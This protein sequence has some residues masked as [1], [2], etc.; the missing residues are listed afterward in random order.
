[1]TVRPSVPSIRDDARGLVDPSVAA[2]YLSVDRVAPC[3]ELVWAVE[4][5]WTVRWRVPD[6][7]EQRVV[8]HPSVHL[9]FEADGAIVTGLATGEWTRV[10]RG[11]GCALGT[12]F[13]SGGFRPFFGRSVG[14]LTDTV[15]PLGDVVDGVDDGLVAEALFH[16]RG[17]DPVAAIPAAERVLLGLTTDSRE[18]SMAVSAVVEWVVDVTGAGATGAGAPAMRVG[19]LAEALG[20]TVR[21]LQRVFADVVGVG[22]KW[23]IDRARVLEASERVRRDPAVRLSDLA[24]ELGF[25]DQAHLTRSFAAAVGQ[26]PARYAAKITRPTALT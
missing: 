11:D 14:E 17:G 1:M 19:V 12:R 10:L 22:P 25:A 15:R 2:R 24:A 20:V 26:S 9:T 21:Q 16:V 6:E 8:P 18:L 3:A 4:Y 23:V 5:H 13:R 7:F